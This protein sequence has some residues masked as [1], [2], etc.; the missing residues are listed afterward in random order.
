MSATNIY[1]L[2]LQ[3][4]NEPLPVE[5]HLEKSLTWGKFLSTLHIYTRREIDLHVKKCGKLKGKSISKTPVRG[6]LFKLESFLSS[7]SIYTVFNLLYF[8]VKARCKASMK[9]ELRNVRIQLCKRK[10]EVYKATC[11][12]PAGKSA[13]CNHVMTLLYEIAEYSLNQLTEVPQEK[14]CTSVL[15]KWGVPGNK[16]VVKEN[17]M[18]T[19]LTSSGQKKGIS[20][21]LYDARLNFNQIKNV[22]SMLKFCKIDKN[23]GFAHVIPDTP[24]FDDNPL[25]KFGLRLLGSPLSY[26]LAPIEINF[27]ILSN[28]DNLPN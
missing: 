18:R 5:T 13:Y 17:V 23:I 16:E 10:G 4:I 2:L 12:C 7:D 24:V 14:A 25:T 28:L 22:P 11:S 26:Q 3:N 21:T 8:Y 1:E 20:P 27:S 15:R 6:R 19:T 9:K